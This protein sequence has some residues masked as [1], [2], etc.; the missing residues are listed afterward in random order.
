M[1]KHSTGGAPRVSGPNREPRHVK[2][3]EHIFVTVASFDGLRASIGECACGDTRT[4]WRVSPI[5]A[6][7]PLG[8]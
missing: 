2:P 6:A 8:S 3:H 7:A 4:I 5:G 1:A